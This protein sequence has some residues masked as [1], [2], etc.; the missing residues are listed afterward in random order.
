MRLIKGS[1]NVPTFL[2][3]SLDEALLNIDYQEE[4]MFVWMHNRAKN[5]TYTSIFQKNKNMFNIDGLFTSL[6][7]VFDEAFI[8]H[9]LQLGLNFDM[10]ISR[11]YKKNSRLLLMLME[12]HPILSLVRHSSSFKKETP[13]YFD[14]LNN[15]FKGLEYYNK[16]CRNFAALFGI[17]NTNATELNE[18]TSTDSIIVCFFGKKTTYQP[19]CNSN[20]SKLRVQISEFRP[21]G[22]QTARG[23]RL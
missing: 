12:D 18:A 11:F 21:L 6:Q 22:P 4:R 3:V 19:S 20:C 23:T 10:P 2:F 16:Q 1:A 15:C 7:G 8:D 13:P 9:V 14:S 17:N 5:N